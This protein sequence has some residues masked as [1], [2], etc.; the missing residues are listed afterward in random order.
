MSEKLHQ[1]AGLNNLGIELEQ[2]GDTNGAIRVYEDNIALEYPATH[3]FDRLLILYRNIRG[4]E[5]EARVA[6]KAI[7]VFEKENERRAMYSINSNPSLRQTILEALENNTRALDDSGLLVFNPFDITK[8][9]KRLEKIENKSKAT[10]N[11]LPQKANTYKPTSISLGAQFQLAILKV[12]EFDFYKDL[13]SGET[14]HAQLGNMRLHTKL[15]PIW[16]VQNKFKLLISTA[17]KYEDDKDYCSAARV[18]EQIVGEEYY[19]PAP[20]DRLI[21]IYAK[22]KLKDDERR[23]LEYSISYFIK[24][25]DHQKEYLSMLATKYNKRQFY[26]ER[27]RNKQK[28]FYYSGVFEL[29]NPFTIIEKWKER[30]SKIKS[31]GV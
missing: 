30:L 3:S 27:V 7:E 20:Y 31:K 5:N 9:R 18:Y 29:Y 14:T 4:S 21:K 19:S 15:S 1:T 11:L 16:E 6:R 12:P 26:L 25:R 10:S 23:L 2:R 13:K 17:K 8:Y 24:L 28:I 22:A